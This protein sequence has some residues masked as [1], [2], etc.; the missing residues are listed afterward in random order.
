MRVFFSLLAAGV[1][2]LWPQTPAQRSYPVWFSERLSVSTAAQLEQRLS[3]PF[4]GGVAHPDGIHNCA[5]WLAKGGS[6]APNAVG[7]EAM[8]QTS[9]LAQC[10]ILREMQGAAASGV[11]HVSNL[12]WDER[13]LPLLPPQLGINVSRETLRSA[14]MAAAEGRAWIDVDK[15]IAAKGAGA[16]RIDVTGQDFTERILLWGRGDFNHDGVEDLLVQCF[17]TLT[18]GT[19]RNTRVFVLTRRPVGIGRQSNRCGIAVCRCG[20][21]APKRLPSSYL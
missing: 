19:Y 9:A 18:K 12:K 10:L 3:E 5:V 21:I 6:I 14:R 7:P 1:W 16:D 11:S 20:D 2:A 8:A 13:V 4:A 17:D 15:T